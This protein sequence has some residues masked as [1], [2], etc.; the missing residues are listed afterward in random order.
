[1]IYYSIIPMDFIMKQPPEKYPDTVE[2]NYKGE[3]VQAIPMGNNK[4]MITRLIST[5]PKAYLN[6]IYQPGNVIKLN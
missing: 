2:I 1:M 5:S 4:Y 6:P 3:I